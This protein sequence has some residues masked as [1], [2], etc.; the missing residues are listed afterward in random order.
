MRA[1]SP[2]CP[3]ALI[4]RARAPPLRPPRARLCTHTRP[5]PASPEDT[6]YQQRVRGLNALYIAAGVIHLV[7]AFQYIF[8]WMPLGYGLLHPVMIPEYLN[9]VGAALYLWSASLYDANLT[10]YTTGADGSV[11]YGASVLL[12]HEIETASALIEVLAAV[13]WCVVW[14]LAYT[15]GPSRGYTLDDP[16]FMGNLLILVP[17]IIYLVY[18]VQNLTNPASF[19]TNSLYEIGDT[20]YF[21]GSV[22]FLCSSLRD[23]GWIAG[24]GLWPAARAALGA[25]GLGPRADALVERLYACCERGGGGGG[26]GKAVPLLDAE[27][28]PLV[29]GG[30]AAAGASA[31][32][33]RATTRGS[34]GIYSAWAEEQ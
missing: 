6:L 20:W 23:D 7:N 10:D 24:F 16:D 17:S 25:A 28:V 31:G 4:A 26:G 1:L 8:A 15:P 21:V 34:R 2:P 22:F 33:G 19:G 29:A 5:P 32:S 11:T 12:T 13:G 9:I 14:A 27:A 3:L 18:N 30:S